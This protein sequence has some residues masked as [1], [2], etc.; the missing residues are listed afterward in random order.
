VL[1]VIEE[2]GLLE[3]AETVGKSIRSRW[4]HVSEEVPEVGDIRGVGAMVGVEFVTDRESK[5]PA[6]EFTGELVRG[7]LQRGVVPVTC[8]PYHNVLRHLVPLVITDKQLEEGLDVLA[9]SAM[10][11]SKKARG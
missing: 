9:D 11:V 7:A 4:E 5:E 6:G 8:G 10:A 2:E 3:R 1:D